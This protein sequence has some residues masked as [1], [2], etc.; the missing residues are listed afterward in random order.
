MLSG[1]VEQAGKWLWGTYNYWE[2]SGEARHYTR[3]ARSFVWANRVHF[4]TIDALGGSASVPFFKRYFLGGASSIR[5]WG[6]FEVSPLS[7]FGLADR[8]VV[9]AGG[10]DGNP[11][12]ARSASS[13]PSAFFD[14]GN[15]SD[16]LAQLSR[17]S[18]CTRQGPASDI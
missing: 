12:A 9:D 2:V 8:R 15:V 18:P 17:Q 13:E 5:G 6:R 16:R 1:H 11:Q 14:F 10:V 3:V 7:G 4:G